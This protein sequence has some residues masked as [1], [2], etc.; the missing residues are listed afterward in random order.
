MG[1]A[2]STAV[3]ADG[4]EEDSVKRVLVQPATAPNVNF[5][6]DSGVVEVCLSPQDLT[7]A[8]LT[9]LTGSDASMQSRNKVKRAQ[10]QDAKNAKFEAP[11]VAEMDESRVVRPVIAYKNQDF[12]M[13]RG[14]RTIRILAENHEAMD[15]LSANGVK[16]FVLV[17]TC[18]YCASPRGDPHFLAR[19][20]ASTTTCS[21]SALRVV[22]AQSRLRSSAIS[23]RQSSLTPARAMLT[24]KRQQ[25]SWRSSMLLSGCVRFTTACP[26]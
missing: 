6:P 20:G 3:Q 2:A 8:A 13:S 1:C 19:V 5:E 22:V 23:T 17:R 11:P 12:L 18:I 14:A 25:K 7:V 10:S 16:D 24:R 9:A 26:S 4:A 15:R 21:F